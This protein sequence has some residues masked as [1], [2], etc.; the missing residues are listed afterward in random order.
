MV[1]PLFTVRPLAWEPPDPSRF[2][3]VMMTSANA[4]R[5]GG[6]GLASYRHLPVYAVGEATAAAARHA[7]FQVATIGDSDAAA[8]LTGI[9]RSGNRRLL[10]LRGSDQGRITPGE[11]HVS[12]V[13]VYAF[14]AAR[15]LHP[16]AAAACLAGAV[17]AVHSPRAA[18]RLGELLDTADIP[19][20]RVFL[21]AISPAT[22]RAAGAGWRGV[23][24]SPVPT[25]TAMLAIARALCETAA[26]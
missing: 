25:D 14:D 21:V 17:A 10:H 23:V 18:A 9:A 12:E 16:E 5:Q 4:A 1:A 8:L 15:H 26:P 22:A 3:A 6:P 13:P 24:A 19:R 2:D 11:L 20:D 7:G